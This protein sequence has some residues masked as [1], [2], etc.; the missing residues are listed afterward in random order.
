LILRIGH[1]DALWRT[2]DWIDIALAHDRL[3][4]GESY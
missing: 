2:Y 4:R 1:D 3:R